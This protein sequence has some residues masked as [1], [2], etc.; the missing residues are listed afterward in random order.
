MT[1]TLLRN[2]LTAVVCL[3]VGTTAQAQQFE[4]S[5]E[6][7]PTTDYSASPIAFNLTEVA[8]ALGSDAATL[9]AA[10]SEY[11][12]A[13]APATSL[14][15]VQQ[16]DG[17]E[18]SD[19]TADANGFW[20]DAQG[21]NVGYG[22]TSVFYASPDVDIEADEFAFYVGQMPEVMQA[23][24]A[25]SAKIALKFN[26]KQVVF[27]ITLNVIAK[28]VYDIPEPATL[29]EKEIN[30]VGEKEVVVE[31]FPRGG[32][33][34][35]AVK[36]ALDD[37][38]EK[39]GLPAVGIL[40]DAMDQVLYAP[41]YNTADV[42]EG[43]GLKKDTLSNTFTAGAPG[44]WMRPVQNELGEET[45][46]C[47]SAEW[48]DADKFFAEAFGFNAETMELTFNLGQYPGGCKTD[49]EWFSY[50]YL[51]YGDKAYRVKITLKVLE[52]EQGTGMDAYTK[53][54]QAA[55]TVKQ[56]PRT[57]WGSVQ[58]Y[59]DLETIAQA[60]GCEVSAIG[61]NALDNNDNFG[62]TTANNGGFWFDEGGRV[63]AYANGAFYIEPAAAND[64]S[65]L[66][67]GQKPNTYT[68][69]DQF[70][71]SLY[72]MNGENYY[73]YDVT[74]LIDDPDVVEHGFESVATRTF[75]LQSLLYNGYEPMDLCNIAIDEVEQL[76]GTASP[77]L[78]GLTQDTLVAKR[79]TYS[80]DWSCDPNPGFW[81]N[82][83]G[84]VSDWY[85]ANARVGICFLS[86]GTFRFFQHPN[87]NSVGEVF[88]TQLF[89]VNEATEKM[90]TININLRFVDSVVEKEIVG[91]E[92]LGIPVSTDEIDV[93]LDLSKPAEALGVTIDDLLSSDSYYLRGLTTD[94]VYGE[95]QNAEN[96][97]SFDMDGGYNGYG[98]MYFTIARNGDDVVLTMCSNNEVADDYTANG[99]FCFEVGDKQ[100]VYYVTF[101]AEPIYNGITTVS[102]DLKAKECYDLQGRR[103]AQ[104]TRGLYIMN[105]RKFIVK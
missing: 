22:E 59:P 82:A 66:N 41:E 55:V 61:M 45:G 8:T 72:F 42:E 99:Q 44:F 103:I 1:K 70:T 93:V 85:D 14:F 81:L 73:Q 40:V 84:R 60:L 2:L 50:V 74:L 86:D 18:S 76:I 105:G 35:D 9:G 68:Y 16:A 13:E 11:I 27:A 26:D 92:N 77:V 63:V 48:G 89:L 19:P 36:V 30:V 56:E 69:G 51:V 24:D 15:F 78:Y 7:Y 31:Q 12:A 21:N 71:A 102:N 67:V 17:T 65:T 98:D 96:G 104:P 80:K 97:L 83:D 33:D 5:A 38:I 49:D 28:P 58:V 64:Y 32:Y 57:S 6:Q 88:S 25:A 47:A 79:G 100:Y 39:L 94:G 3:L 34:S 91:N 29:I 87:R 53:V 101:M 4:G 37:V 43:G 52:V 62:Q 75:A 95:G 10:I 46:E 23:G 54:G 90:V 20:M